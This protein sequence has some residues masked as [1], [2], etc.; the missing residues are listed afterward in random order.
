MEIIIWQIYLFYIIIIYIFY[1]CQILISDM[2]KFVSLSLAMTIVIISLI[3]L[4]L[5]YIKS[6]WCG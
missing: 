2:K 4:G 1:P 3:S 5:Y 6:R